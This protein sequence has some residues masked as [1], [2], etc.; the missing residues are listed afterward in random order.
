L[1]GHLKKRQELTIH[2]ERTF[3]FDVSS[4]D[5]YL[6]F[7]ISFPWFLAGFKRYAIDCNE[8]QNPGLGYTIPYNLIVPSIQIST[9]KATVYIYDRCLADIPSDL[10]DSVI[11][12]HFEQ[13][14][15]EVAAADAIFDRQSQLLRK[16][17]R[18]DLVSGIGFL[19]AVF[20]V[21]KTDGADLTALF[22]TVHDQH[23]VKL[24]ITVPIDNGALDES[25]RITFS[26]VEAF[27]KL[28]WNLGTGSLGDQ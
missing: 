1:A 27:E 11:A 14:V 25:F 20:Q 26:F 9:G 8:T 22:L 28:L 5:Q 12:E 3:W 10:T 13:L 24:R 7:G 17:R 16:F 18:G 15:D 21:H 23:F 2:I 4:C 6:L 19:G